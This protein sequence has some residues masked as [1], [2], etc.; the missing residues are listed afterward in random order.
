MLPLILAHDLSPGLGCGWRVWKFL[1][2]KFDQNIRIEE[3]PHEHRIVFEDYGLQARQM[4]KPSHWDY[5]KPTRGG[6]RGNMHFSSRKH[7]K[8]RY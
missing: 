8:D 5:E 4:A 1:C 3:S 7:S 2:N 6:H